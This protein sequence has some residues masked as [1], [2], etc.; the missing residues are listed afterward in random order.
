VRA[1][2]C[3]VSKICRKVVKSLLLKEE[4]GN[5]VTVNARNL[6]KLLG[7]KRYTYGQAEKNNQVGQVTG[8]AWTEVGGE[9]LTIET[10]VMPGKGKT[11]TTG[12]LGEV[13]QE[14]V[15]AALSV[16]R[17][18]SRKLGIESDFYQK[19]DIHIHLPEG[20]TPKDGPSAGIGMCTALVSVLTGIPVRADVAMTGEIT[21]RGE[22]LP[23]GGLKE[24]LLAAHRGGIKTV[25]IPEENTK[26]LA[27]IPD[28]V[29]NRLDIHPVKWI[30]RVFELAL[31]RLPEPLPAI[32]AK[33][34]AP[35][36]QATDADGAVLKH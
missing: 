29:K 5:K 6:Q 11:I 4:R 1:M 27:E 25:L 7:V 10:V 16:V 19:N 2:E 32:E 26:D 20:A 22:V 30:D 28:N 34:V 15:Q 36:P 23:I 33:D 17:N 3:E 13:M 9:L 24:K 14:S 21:L 31:E 8:L 18:R 12:K 35:I